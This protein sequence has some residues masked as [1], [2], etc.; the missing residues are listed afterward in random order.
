MILLLIEY[1]DFQDWSETMSSI[2]CATASFQLRLLKNL[3]IRKEV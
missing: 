2:E 3:Q 1:N